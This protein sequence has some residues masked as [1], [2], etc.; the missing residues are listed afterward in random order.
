LGP[1]VFRSRR[2]ISTCGFSS[3]L[4]SRKRLGRCT[5]SLPSPRSAE[6]Y[7]A[8]PSDLPQEFRAWPTLNDERLLWAPVREFVMFGSTVRRRGVFR[9]WAEYGD[10]QAAAGYCACRRRERSGRNGI[11][12][13]LMRRNKPSPCGWLWRMAVASRLG[14]PAADSIDTN[15]RK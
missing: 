1:S 3:R 14:F 8:S 9:S 5:P 4:F 13:S 2:R 10:Q 12:E 7:D 11:A 6:P 15:P